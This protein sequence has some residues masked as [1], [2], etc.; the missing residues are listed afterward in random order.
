[1]LEGGRCEAE[2]VDLQVLEW[3]MKRL[4]RKPSNYCAVP[5]PG[6]GCTTVYS[7]LAVEPLTASSVEFCVSPSQ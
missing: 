5:E 4:N 7:S 2:D 3:Q 6:A 1:M